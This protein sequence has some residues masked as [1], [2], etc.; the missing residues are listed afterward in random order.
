MVQAS[1]IAVHGISQAMID[2]QTA[3]VPDTD[4]GRSK[5]LAEMM[6]IA[7]GAQAAVLRLAGLYGR[8]GSSHL[9]LNKTIGDAAAGIAPTLRGSGKAR[10][11]Y[12]HV[13]DAA[14]AIRH[15]LQ[16]RLVGT[17]ALGGSET[18]TMREILDTVRRVFTPNAPLREE[19]GPDARDQLV[20]T[21]PALPVG[22]SMADALRDR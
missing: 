17:F 10:R 2:S 19:P 1:S 5:H 9:S 15:C 11:N 13:G 22:R 4:Y 16:Q 8:E 21:D 7:A 20:I 3:V 14:S 18:L 12:L 6:I